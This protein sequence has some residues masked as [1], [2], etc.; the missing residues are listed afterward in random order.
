MANTSSPLP[1]EFYRKILAQHDL[2]PQTIGEHTVDEFAIEANDIIVGDALAYFI[3]DTFI[4]PGMPPNAQW[5]EIL[6]A[7]R[8]HGLRI[9]DQEEK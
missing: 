3:G 8:V 9:T 5:C 1:D 2:H 6:R 4:D 7:L